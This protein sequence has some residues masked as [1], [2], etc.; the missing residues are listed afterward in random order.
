MTAPQWIMAVFL[1]VQFAGLIWSWLA[2][3]RRSAPVLNHLPRWMRLTINH[4][5]LMTLSPVG[6]ALTLWSGD[7]W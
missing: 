1:V 3:R 2:L 4:G 6:E 7:F 5:W